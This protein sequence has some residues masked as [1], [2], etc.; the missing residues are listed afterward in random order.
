VLELSSTPILQKTNII[1]SCIYVRALTMDYGRPIK[2]FF[3]EIPDFW[4][5]VDKFRGIWCIFARLWA[6]I[7]VLGVPCPCFPLF[8][9]YFYK[10]LSLYIH[11]TNIYLLEASPTQ[12]QWEKDDSNFFSL[13]ATAVNVCVRCHA[14]NV[15][16]SAKFFPAKKK[17][18]DTMYL[19]IRIRF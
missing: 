10:K 19:C 9:H 1:N 16:V 8:N 2:P 18:I 12:F 7:L 15:Q 3:I 17:P 11:I 13:Q 4:A 14:V 5:W 6:S